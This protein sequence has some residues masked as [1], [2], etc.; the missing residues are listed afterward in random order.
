LKHVLKVKGLEYPRDYKLL[1]IG[2]SPQTYA[3][4]TAGQIDAAALSLPLNYAAEEA[5]FNDIG[6]FVDV[7]PN[8]QLAALSLKRSW[9]EKNRP[10]VVRFMK[11]M[12][13][14][15]HWIYL[16]KEPA[17]DF[18]SKEMNL[19][20]DHARRGW[21]FYTAS[22]MWHPDGDLNVEGLQV[23]AQIY[24]EQT[25]AKTPVPNAAKYVDQSYLREALKELGK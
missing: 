11:A 12:A 2:G 7:I 9:G 16:N 17:V 23:V 8:Y 21:E 15:M 10:V 20:R 1:V 24:A 5:G 3:A 13:Q 6:R 25:Q 19:K 4:L 22:R 14:T 18:L